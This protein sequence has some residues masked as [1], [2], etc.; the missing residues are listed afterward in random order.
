MSEAS[1]PV[2]AGESSGTQHGWGAADAQPDPR[3]W[4]ILVV[5]AIAQLMVVLDATVMN[6]ALPSAQRDLGFSVVDRQWIVTA[7]SLS[8]GSLLLFGGRL[9]DLIGRRMMFI[10][11]LAGFAIASAIGGASVNFAMLVTARA[12]QGVFGAMLAPAALSLLATTF[13]DPKE[14]GKAFGIYGS[15]AAGGG[16]VGLLLG[17]ALTSYL[18]WRWCLYINLFFAGLAIAG[19]LMFLHGRSGPR[20]AQLD[21]PGVLAVSSGVFC[22]VYGFSNAATHSWATPSTYLFLAAGVVLLAVFVFWMSRAA[23]PLMPPRVVL[24]RNRGAAYLG[25][26]LAGAGM[27]GIFLFVT[28]YLQET[29]NYS[30]VITGVAFLPMVV[31][32]AIAS[33]TSNIVL[34]PRIG[35][36][37]IISVGLGLAAVGMILFTRIG[38]HSGYAGTILPALLVTGLGMGLMFSTAFNTGTFGVSPRDAGVASAMVNTGQQLGGSIGTS[39]LNT[40]FA[41]AT[42]GYVATNLAAHGRGLTSAVIANVKASAAIHGYVTAFWWVAGIFLFGA[43]VCGTLMRRGPLQSVAPSGSAASAAAPAAGTK[44]DAV[45]REGAET[46][47]ADPVSTPE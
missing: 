26:L 40:I 9:A 27:F 45:A 41:S 13:T 6:I 22:L 5:I 35:P 7:Y 12:C 15:V 18:S 32:I 1:V 38:L 33:N 28:Y 8:F 46:G 14:R 29:L 42:A 24:D 11:G 31:C 39:L 47:A 43:V 19:A 10:I 17:G 21:I 30:P 16:A 44:V 20:Q 4:L 37:P 25:I 36:K 23:S 3:R 34:M 2:P